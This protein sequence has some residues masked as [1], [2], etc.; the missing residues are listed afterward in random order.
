GPGARGDECLGRGRPPRGRRAPAAGPRFCP[1]HG[2]VGENGGVGCP[3][4]GPLCRRDPPDTPAA[5]RRPD[6]RAACPFGAPP[7]TDR[8]AD[9]GAE[10]PGGD[11]RAPYE[12]Y[13]CPY[14]VAQW[15]NTRA[16]PRPRDDA[17]GQPPVAGKRRYVAEGPGYFGCACTHFS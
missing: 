9:R 3:R 12:G 13:C 5:A 10:P 4:P 2:P 14:Y 15:G 1:G 8:Y 6:A 11:E 7:A 17:P 16:G